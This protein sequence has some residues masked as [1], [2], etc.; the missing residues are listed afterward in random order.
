VTRADG[1]LHLTLQVAG[2][3]GAG[4]HAVFDAGQALAVVH[5]HW[6]PNG[7]QLAVMV[8]AVGG[9]PFPPISPQQQQAALRAG[10]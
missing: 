1:L 4:R 5:P 7:R 9:S 8:F 6:S 3:D 2:P 10:Q